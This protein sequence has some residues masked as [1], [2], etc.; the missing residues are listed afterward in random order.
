MRNRKNVH[1]PFPCRGETSQ[2]KP[3]RSKNI[4]L[5]YVSGTVHK[6]IAFL[7][8]TCFIHNTSALL[9]VPRRPTPPTA[10]STTLAP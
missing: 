1:V 7:H 6:Q 2:R 3:L 4:Q 9:D 5:E 10:T 8:S